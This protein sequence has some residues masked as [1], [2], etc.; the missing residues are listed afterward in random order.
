VNEAFL[1]L[2]GL[3]RGQVVGKAT[4]EVTGPDIVGTLVP[5]RERVYAGEAF[6]FEREVVDA[7]GRTRWIRARCVPDLRFD[8]TVKGE[9]VVGHDITDLKQ[10]QDALATREGQ[11]TAI[12]NGVPAPVAYID[13][14]E[15]CHYVNR[16]FL[17]FFGLTQDEVSQ[18]RLADVVGHGIY[19]SAQVQR[20]AEM[21]AG[22]S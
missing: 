8:G 21:P 4:D 10:A 18:M 6:T 11:L 22:R 12:I 14:G 20:A 2:V 13:R 3:Q 9:Y 7:G 19:Q 16:A 15:R 5:G 1:S 17:Q